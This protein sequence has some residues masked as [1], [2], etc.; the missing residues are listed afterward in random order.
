MQVAMLFMI[1]IGTFAKQV[2]YK[3]SQNFC[4]VWLR[5]DLSGLCGVVATYRHGKT[6]FAGTNPARDRIFLMFLYASS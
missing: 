3:F 6:E 2:G 1:G 5:W 4:R